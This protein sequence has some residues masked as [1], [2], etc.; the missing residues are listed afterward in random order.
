MSETQTK[1]DKKKAKIQVEQVTLRSLPKVIF[2]YPL[3]FT[4]LVL[5]IIQGVLGEPVAG[6]GYFWVAIFFVNLFVIAFDFNSTKFFV[7]VLAIVVVI[8]LVIFLV[9]P[10]F[11]LP[12]ADPD[13][14]PFNIGLAFEFYMVM[15]I[16]LGAILALVVIGSRFDYW[17]VERNELYHKS[18][19][20]GDAQR[21]PVDKLRFEKDIPDVFELLTLK[22]GSITLRPDKDTVIHLP[23]VVNVNLK[24]QQL[25]Y[26]LSHKKVEI[27]QID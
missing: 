12:E 4:S 1:E 2:F 21:Y 3:F 10:N 16:I 15:T 11:E 14:E 23:T 9:V 8:L 24:E 6:L 26:L 25:D 7:L 20:L 19:I 18:G 27:D 17:K 13:A 22:A 5:M